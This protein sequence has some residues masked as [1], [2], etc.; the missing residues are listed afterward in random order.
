MSSVT[1]QMKRNKSVNTYLAEEQQPPPLAAL[2]QS[3]PPPEEQHCPEGAAD[4]A[5][6][7]AV[8]ETLFIS[9]EEQSGETQL[10]TCG[11]PGVQCVFTLHDY[12]QKQRKG[13]D[14]TSDGENAGGAKM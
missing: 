14:T 3:S 8:M 7:G 2:P 12:T 1:A 6:T 11:V 4:S 13:R 5:S 10:W 9:A